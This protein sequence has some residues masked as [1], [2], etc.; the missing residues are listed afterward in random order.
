MVA[1]SNGMIKGNVDSASSPVD[2]DARRAPSIYGKLGFD[3]KS[4]RRSSFTLIR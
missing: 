4:I 3:R 1:A 2:N